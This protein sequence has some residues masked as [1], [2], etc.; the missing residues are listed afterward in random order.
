MRLA[1]GRKYLANP[2]IN[3]RHADL[4][5]LVIL[6]K[7]KDLYYP[8]IKDPVARIKKKLKTIPGTDVS[9][10]YCQEQTEVHDNLCMTALATY[11]FEDQ[12]LISDYLL[13]VTLRD[14]NLSIWEYISQPSV[15]KSKIVDTITRIDRRRHQYLHDLYLDHQ[16]RQ[17]LL[18]SLR[19]KRK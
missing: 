7:I 8:W 14:K 6:L 13:E 15:K 4:S 11:L 19:E 3:V 10:E 18:I 9:T 1:H 5:Q 12:T 2:F 16:S 17:R